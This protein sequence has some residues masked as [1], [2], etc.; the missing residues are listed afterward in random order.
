MKP[1]RGGFNGLTMSKGMASAYDIA[2]STDQ[3]VDGITCSTGE[4]IDMLLQILKNWTQ[5]STEDELEDVFILILNLNELTNTSLGS[6][7]PP[8]PTPPPTN[9]TTAAPMLSNEEYFSKLQSPNTN[10]T[11]KAA[12]PNMISLKQLFKNVF[13]SEI[14]TPV[15]HEEDR[16]DL[17]AT[18]IVGIGANNLKSNSTYNITDDLTTIYPPGVLGSMTNSSLIKITSSLT[19]DKCSF[20]M[21]GMMMQPTGQ[22]ENMTWVQDQMKNLTESI[23][24]EPSWSFASMSDSNSAPWTFNTGQLATVCGFSPLVEMGSS[25]SYSEQAAMS[26]WSWDLD[27]PPINETTSRN[28][29]CGAMQGNGRWTAQNCNTKLPVACRKIGTSSEWIIY[30]KGADNYRDVTCPDDYQFDVPR[31]ARENQLLY[32]TLLRYVNVTNPGLFKSITNMQA[33]ENRL[34]AALKPYPSNTFLH[35]RH[36]NED[37]DAKK[38]DKDGEEKEAKKEPRTRMDKVVGEAPPQSKSMVS[39]TQGASNTAGQAGTGMIWIDISSWQTAG[40]WVPGGIQGKCPYQDPDNTV[41]LQEIIKVSSIGGVIILVLV[42]M[43]LYLKCRR[44]VRLRRAN[45]RR[46]DVR[47]KIMRTEVE[48]VPA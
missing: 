48:T 47:N 44:N 14:Y 24:T 6:R 5:Q 42:G 4:D 18:I 10:H 21:P 33:Y 29:R 31:T 16:Q 46:T 2:T 19:P 40:C 26:I 7:T 45:K 1:H 34:Q 28:L 36:E 15:R 9:Q 37:D 30:E 25:L 23:I 27:Q 22:E 35:R 43:F 3:T 41:A 12:L 20:P 17:F 38:G 39:P 32:Q 8:A 11:I 13:P